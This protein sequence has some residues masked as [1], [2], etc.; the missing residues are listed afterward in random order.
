M[1]APLHVLKNGTGEYDIHVQIKTTMLCVSHKAFL[2]KD[3][4]YVNSTMYAVWSCHKI[5]IFHK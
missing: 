4:I 3:K 5:L 2:F 1:I